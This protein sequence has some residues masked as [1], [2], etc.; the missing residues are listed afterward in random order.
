MDYIP[1]ETRQFV[2]H[3]MAILGKYDDPL[4]HYGYNE[5]NFYDGW[6]MDSGHDMPPDYYRDLIYRLE[7]SAKEKQIDIQNGTENIEQNTARYPFFHETVEVIPVYKDVISLERIQP[8]VEPSKIPTLL[9]LLSIPRHSEGLDIEN[10]GHGYHFHYGK[11]KSNSIERT[12]LLL[13]FDPAEKPKVTNDIGTESNPCLFAESHAEGKTTKIRIET[14][15]LNKRIPIYSVCLVA[16]K[17]RGYSNFKR[18]G[19]ASSEFYK[20][21]VSNQSVKS[22][23]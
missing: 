2:R 11:V 16:G 1:Q 18:P 22:T 7:E 9:Y 5:Y 10:H 21:I 6:W 20:E 15:G 14:I 8:L 12:N 17:K 13:T 3:S 23:P 4:V 19:S